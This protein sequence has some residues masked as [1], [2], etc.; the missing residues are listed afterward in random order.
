MIDNHPDKTKQNNRSRDDD[1]NP[2]SFLRNVSEKTE[3]ADMIKEGNAKDDK[4]RRNHEEN[5]EQN[6]GG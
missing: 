3:A 6:Y 2:V 1:K 4:D 5:C